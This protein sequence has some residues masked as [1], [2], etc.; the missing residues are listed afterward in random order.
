MAK[1]FEL[2]KKAYVRSNISKDR[3]YKNF[4][5]VITVI[6]LTNIKYCK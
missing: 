1:R 3:K 2:L 5:N 4:C 6:R